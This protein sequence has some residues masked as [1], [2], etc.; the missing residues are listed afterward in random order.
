MRAVRYLDICT[1]VLVFSITSIKSSPK[2]EFDPD[3]GVHPYYLNQTPGYNYSEC[4]E[5]AKCRENCPEI[6][7]RPGFSRSISQGY[8]R[9]ECL[10]KCDELACKLNNRF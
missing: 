1:V 3:K 6:R 2:N 10:R 4:T 7:S 5:K 8:L 9:A